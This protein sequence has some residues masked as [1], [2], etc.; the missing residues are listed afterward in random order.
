MFQIAALISKVTGKYLFYKDYWN[1]YPDSDPFFKLIAAYT[2]FV[3]REKENTYKLVHWD[4][5]RIAFG[6]FNEVLL[7]LA[8]TLDT[9]EQNIEKYLIRTY[10]ML[11]AIFGDLTETQNIPQNIEEFSRKLESMIRASATKEDLEKLDY[12]I[13]E[14]Y[15]VTA[16]SEEENRRIA[17]QSEQ[18]AKLLDQFAIEMLDGSI[19]RFKLFL[20]ASVTLKETIHYEVI[21]D[22]STYPHPP[23]FEFPSKL[24][25]ILGDAGETLETI[26]NWDPV[27]PPEWVEVVQELEQ[28]VY[29]SET[30]LIEPIVEEPEVPQ[31]KKGFAKQ[32]NMPAQKEPKGIPYPQDRPKEPKGIPYPADTPVRP[33]EPKGTPFIQPQNPPRPAKAST[34][35]P[36]PKPVPFQAEPPPSKEE[37]EAEPVKSEKEEV[38]CPNCGFIFKSPNEKFC[39]LCGSPRPE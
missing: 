39:Q 11:L 35:P 3:V 25:D 5:L 18:A 12:S 10:E 17:L 21:V 22:F 27:N 8:A 9:S 32:L 20:T 14:R 26:Q 15:G 37:E 30:H 4:K 31:K 2:P 23:M 24:H 13:E 16:A 29:Q 28:M 38:A 36:A 6:N 19:S 33:K 7:I 1:K 34:P